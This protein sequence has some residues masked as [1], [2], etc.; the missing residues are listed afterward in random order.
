MKQIELILLEEF[1]IVI[2]KKILGIIPFIDAG[3]FIPRAKQRITINK[4][5]ETRMNNPNYFLFILMEIIFDLRRQL[6]QQLVHPFSIRTCDFEHV[7][8]RK[9]EARWESKQR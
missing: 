4:E 3:G 5:L 9:Y 6:R 7:F 2:V 1:C 8:E